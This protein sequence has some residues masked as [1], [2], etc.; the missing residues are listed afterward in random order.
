[1]PSLIKLPY[2]ALPN[3]ILSSTTSLGNIS[4][5]KTKQI[6]S[7]MYVNKHSSYADILTVMQ[8][9]PFT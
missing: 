2:K 9:V 4:I 1:M 8:K 5:F 6:N 7:I 3:S